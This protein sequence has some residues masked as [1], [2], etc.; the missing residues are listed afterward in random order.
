MLIGDSLWGAIAVFAAVLLV[1]SAGLAWR[2]HRLAGA[3]ARQRR[4]LDLRGGLIEAAPGGACLWHGAERRFEMTPPLAR[5]IGLE[6]DA[7][8]DALLA[9]LTDPDRQRLSEA[10]QVLASQ[11]LSFSLILRTETGGSLSVSGNRALTAAV[12]PLDI[13]WFTD[14]SQSMKLE[15]ARARLER[16]HDRTTQLLDVLPW[17]IWRRARDLSLAWV[18][19]AYSDTL[20]QSRESVLDREAPLVSAAGEEAKALAERAQRSGRPQ[21]ESH[22][23]VVVGQ[24]RLFDVTER[25][26]KGDELVGYAEDVSALAETQDELARHVAAH[27][28]VL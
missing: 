27:A 25:P 8:W 2:N 13:L 26:L 20:G 11:G 10:S 16:E 19:R 12:Q 6:A 7:G 9:S 28:E 15:G 24:R 3:L 21:S 22:S 14:A 1:L 18:N 5:L 23:L 4:A 17:P